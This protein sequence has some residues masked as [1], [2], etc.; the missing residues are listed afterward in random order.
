[1]A[2]LTL[3]ASNYQT[4]RSSNKS[5]HIIHAGI[6]YIKIYR[7]TIIQYVHQNTRQQTG[8]FIIHPRQQK[9]DEKCSNHLYRIDMENAEYKCGN[10]N[11]FC[12]IVLL[13]Q[14]FGDS[15]AKQQFFKNRPCHGDSQDTSPTGLQNIES[16]LHYV[17]Q[18]LHMRN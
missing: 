7:N 6:F 9:P 15:T 8:R 5:I 12:W 3:K 1:M 2:I 18:P 16:L 10:Q 14:G 17:G 4:G 11:C 13:Q